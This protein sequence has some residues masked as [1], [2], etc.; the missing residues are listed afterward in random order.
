MCR[1]LCRPSFGIQKMSGMCR[2]LANA[3]WWLFLL[4][5][6]SSS[7]GLIIFSIMNCLWSCKYS[8]GGPHGKES[9]KTIPLTCFFMCYSYRCQARG[10]PWRGPRGTWGER[11]R[12]PGG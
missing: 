5:S 8:L 3:E 9:P 4:Y 7:P 2:L 11:Q 10:P 1:G 6:K 12:R